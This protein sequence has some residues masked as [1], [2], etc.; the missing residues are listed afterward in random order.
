MDYPSGDYSAPVSGHP[1]VL[2]GEHAGV[3]LDWWRRRWVIMNHFCNFVNPDHRLSTWS[4][5]ISIAGARTRSRMRGGWLDSFVILST[6]F[7]WRWYPSQNRRKYFV[8][9]AHC[10]CNLRIMIY[11]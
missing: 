10:R 1:T 2:L 8:F 3:C 6:S 4:F 11:L 9:T 5:N 7:C